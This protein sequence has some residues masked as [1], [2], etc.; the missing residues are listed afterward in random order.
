[1]ARNNS[2]IS[3]SPF[4]ILEAAAATREKGLPVRLLS[5]GD[6]AA[7][8]P[9]KQA[10]VA[11]AGPVIRSTVVAAS[12]SIDHLVELNDEI[13]GLVRAGIPLDLGLASMRSDLAG[14]L[15]K[16]IASLE[17]AIARGQTLDEALARISHHATVEKG[18]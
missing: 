12:V 18:V 2:G 5:A 6:S 15:R 13:A 3:S 4:A 1:M 14:P 10:D 11:I 9:Y 16:T 7:H 8:A 17:S